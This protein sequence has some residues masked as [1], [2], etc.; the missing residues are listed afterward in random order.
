MANIFLCWI[1]LHSW[2]DWEYLKENDCT[3]LRTCKRSENH[4]KT[5]ELH[6]WEQVKKDNYDSQC[7]NCEG[8]GFYSADWYR[9]GDKYRTV[10]D[11]PPEAYEDPQECLCNLYQICRT[12][13]Q[14]KRVKLYS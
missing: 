5:R 7:P 6:D 8:E 13:K 4:R 11:L 2:N 10:N 1:G 12:C 9:S 14:E 3:Q